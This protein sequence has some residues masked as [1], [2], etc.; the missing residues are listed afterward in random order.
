MKAIERCSSRSKPRR[1]RISSRKS[2][3]A[4][5]CNSSIRACARANWVLSRRIVDLASLEAAGDAAEAARVRRGAVSR[6]ATPLLRCFAAPEAGALV[7]FF[8]R[9]PVEAAYLGLPGFTK[10]G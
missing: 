5:A 7:F 6:A 3:S 10:T 1:F 4:E 9:I 2:V 8:I